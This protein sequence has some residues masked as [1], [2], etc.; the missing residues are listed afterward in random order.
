[1]LSSL[2]WTAMLH[3]KITK[4]GSNGHNSKEAPRKRV[5]RACDRCRLKKGKACL[6]PSPGVGGGGGRTESAIRS[7][8][9]CGCRY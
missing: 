1:V 6:I 9:D 3:P 2:A 8:H 4:D 5:A 7:R